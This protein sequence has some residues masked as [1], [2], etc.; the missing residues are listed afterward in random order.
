VDFA[1]DGHTLLHE[2]VQADPGPSVP[3]VRPRLS[4]GLHRLRLVYTVADGGPGTMEMVWQPPGSLLSII[5]PQDLVPAPAQGP[6]GLAPSGVAPIIVLLQQTTPS[7][8]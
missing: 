6:V 8:F 5:P 2:D 4:R 1:I 3:W 7:S